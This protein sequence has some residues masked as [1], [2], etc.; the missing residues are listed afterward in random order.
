RATA[1]PPPSA[2]SPSS[3]GARAGPPSRGR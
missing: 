2:R 1:S 3:T